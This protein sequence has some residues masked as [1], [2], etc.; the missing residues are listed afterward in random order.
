MAS[1]ETF[2]AD[3]RESHII[4]TTHFLSLPSEL[5]SQIATLVDWPD[6]LH[7]RMVRHGSKLVTSIANADP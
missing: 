2:M 3:T 7:L 6:L 5:L 4:E 1:L